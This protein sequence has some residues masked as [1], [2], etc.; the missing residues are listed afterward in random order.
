MSVR[1]A[2][3]LM[4]GDQAPA[5]VIS[6]AA[7]AL[8]ADPELELLLVGPQPVL[9][10]IGEEPRLR[11]VPSG[12]GVPEGGRP[13]SFLRQHGDASMNRTV[14]LVAEGEADGAVSVGHTGALMIAARWRLGMLPGVLRPAP[15]AVFPLGSQ[16]VLLDIGANVEVSA[17]DFLVFA[18]LGGA[19]CRIV[20]G[21]SQPS[22]ALLANGTE[23]GKGTR[24]LKEAHQLLAQRWPSFVGYVEPLELFTGAADVILTDG[25]VGNIVLKTMEGMARVLAGLPGVVDTTLAPL[26]ARMSDITASGSPILFLG[27][28]GVVVPGHG[29]AGAADVARLVGLATAAVRQGLLAAI[30][31][32]LKQYGIA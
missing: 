27:T 22:V 8:A 10:T 30:E 23:P 11:L 14:A 1:I 9:A 24:V 5:A 15:A 3:D 7:R 21:V 17:E 32:E 2:L 6:G 13:A 20:K 19:F 18:A 12:P 29:R 25:F 4:G 16:P 28:R 26:L 31:A